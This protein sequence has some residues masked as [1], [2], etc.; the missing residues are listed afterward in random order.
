MRERGYPGEILIDQG[1]ND[2]FLDLLNRVERWDVS[3]I[4]QLRLW[5]GEGAALRLWPELE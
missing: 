4:D 2:Q 5:P 3:N 1:A